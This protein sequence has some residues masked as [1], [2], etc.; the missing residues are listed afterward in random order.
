MPLRDG[1]EVKTVPR[2]PELKDGDEVFRMA[3][4]N[5]IFLTYESFIKRRDLYL[6]T[7][8]TCKYTRK[9]DMTFMDALE[10]ERAFVK[11]V[12]DAPEQYIRQ[13]AKKIHLCPSP[14]GTLVA[15]LYTRLSKV[16]YE[17]QIVILY[18]A[19]QRTPKPIVA[20]VVCDGVTSEDP[21]SLDLLPMPPS[22]PRY[23]KLEAAGARR[24][25]RI[26]SPVMLANLP[27]LDAGGSFTATYRHCYADDKGLSKDFLRGLIRYVAYRPDSRTPFVVNATF[28]EKFGLPA[29]PKTLA[30]IAPAKKPRKRQQTLEAA[31]LKRGSTGAASDVAG[32]AAGFPVPDELV[33]E[34]DDRKAR[35]LDGIKWIDEMT[36]LESSQVT[37]LM[38]ILDFI[39]NFRDLITISSELD[40]TG[41]AKVIKLETGKIVNGAVHPTLYQL[42]TGVTA[43]MMD[44]SEYFDDSEEEEEEE[45]EEVPEPEEESDEESEA[46]EPP[47]PVRRSTRVSALAKFAN[48]HTDELFLPRS[49]RSAAA[50]ASQQMSQTSKSI[51][52][53]GDGEAGDEYDYASEEDQDDGLTESE[54]EDSDAMMN[55][56][57]RRSTRLRTAPRDIIES[58]DEEDEEQTSPEALAQVEEKKK[59]QEEKKKRYRP[60]SGT[61]RFR[62]LM[63]S[64]DLDWIADWW[65]YLT[66]IETTQGLDADLGWLKDKIVDMTDCST[67]KM[68][69]R[70]NNPMFIVK[71]FIDLTVEDR[72]K[73]L[74][75][76]VNEM[77]L[78]DTVRGAMKEATDTVDRLRSSHNTGKMAGKRKV[79]ALYAGEDAQSVREKASLVSQLDELT[80]QLVSL[81]SRIDSGDESVAGRIERLVS[82][83]ERIEVD[84]ENVR[85]KAAARAEKVEVETA[86]EQERLDAQLNAALG[87]TTINLGQDRAWRSFWMTPAVPGNLLIMNTDHRW[88]FIEYKAV[89][90]SCD[91]RGVR[92]LHLQRKLK[93]H[94]P[95]LEAGQ[96]VPPG[97]GVGFRL[98]EAQPGAPG[99]APPVEE[100]KEEEEKEG[101]KGKEKPE[102]NAEQVVEEEADVE[103]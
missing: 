100:K 42:M 40:L 8:F 9:G 74:S 58:S 43:L 59:A 30:T 102:E 10:S 53:E 68:R 33:P 36:G 73:F 91:V 98:R 20:T 6:S 87:R 78:T 86:A 80:N 34:D 41:L 101:V 38:G 47:Q 77:T 23:A 90:A 35:Q 97:T 3:E 76:M 46:P 95:V 88:G 1:V 28:R 96:R 21:A 70:D 4:T 57:L 99:L 94:V 103:M 54:E 83:K 51:Y 66:D 48:E 29:P 19:Q 11:K 89:M 82:K 79:K 72:L 65:G 27:D 60:L 37:Q 67:R 7:N 14:I 12:Q 84:L 81:Q 26:K 44:A 13:V 15:E 5:E 25:H 18:V 61:K 24:Y 39:T 32:L 17:G 75:T 45:V 49:R 92:E 22:D 93:K 55:V 63:G 69:D 62:T 56:G 64:T 71:R 2:P 16:Y 50:R 85:A 31:L 52:G